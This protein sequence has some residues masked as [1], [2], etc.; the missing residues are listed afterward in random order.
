MQ[1]YGSKYF[2]RR[3]PNP[4]DG[5]NRSKFNFVIS[6]V[7][8]H[9]KLNGITKCSNMVPNILPSDHHTRPS[10]QKVIVSEQCHIAYQS[11]GN[12][13]CSIMVANTL[14]ADN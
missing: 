7:V 9:I 3:Q 4:G 8:L 13:A 14:P 2:A 10:G 1:H 11:K 12:Y 6:M 5:I